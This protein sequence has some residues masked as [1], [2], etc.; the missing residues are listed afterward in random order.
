MI[1]F[2]FYI[3]AQGLLSTYRFYATLLLYKPK[4]NFSDLHE[5]DT[6]T[7]HHELTF[8]SILSI[9]QSGEEAALINKKDEIR[10]HIASIFLTTRHAQLL[11]YS[12]INVLI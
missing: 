7:S 6:K 11:D 1:N 12:S 2:M 9:S 10:R 5:L 3:N 8:V 4:L